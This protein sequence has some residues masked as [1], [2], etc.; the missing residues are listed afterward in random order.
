VSVQP[1]AVGTKDDDGSKRALF[2]LSCSTAI[3]LLFLYFLHI[4]FE[5]WTH[6]NLFRNEDVA[7][8]FEEE[9]L[10]EEDPARSR[11]GLASA[12]SVFL[13]STATLAICVHYIFNAIDY[14]DSNTELGRSHKAFIG[15]IAL[16]VLSGGAESLTALLVTVRNKVDLVSADVEYGGRQDGDELEL[17]LSSSRQCKL[18]SDRAFKPFSTR[19]RC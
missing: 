3:V 12:L 9:D 1:Y 13:V 10:E 6:W 17:M 16:P 7:A 5:L 19:L 11:L 14:L 4:W 18:S 8:E 2:V 15:L